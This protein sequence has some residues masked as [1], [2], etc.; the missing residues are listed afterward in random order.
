[1]K[2]ML[3]VQNEGGAVISVGGT[4][5]MCNMMNGFHHCFGGRFIN[6]QQYKKAVAADRWWLVEAESAEAGR[7]KIVFGDHTDGGTARILASGGK[8]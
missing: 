6:I 2:V 4:R 8:P 1:M 7:R 5:A 3:M